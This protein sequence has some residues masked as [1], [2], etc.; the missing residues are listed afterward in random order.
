MPSTLRVQG[1][2]GNGWV[3]GHLDHLN[4]GDTDHRDLRPLCWEQAVTTYGL[5]TRKG[6]EHSQVPVAM[7]SVPLILEAA[8]IRGSMYVPTVHFPRRGF[9]SVLAKSLGKFLWTIPS[10][11]SAKPLPQR[12]LVHL[13]TQLLF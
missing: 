2:Q 1:A 13:C 3:P 9:L 6:K 12:N 10:A 8:A 7:V 5:G 11:L 4:E